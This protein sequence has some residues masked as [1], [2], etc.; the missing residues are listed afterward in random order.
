[1][2]ARLD[3][4]GDLCWPVSLI[5]S[6]QYVGHSDPCAVETKDKNDDSGEKRMRV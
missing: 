6:S 4:S 1:M 2:N 5:P 3:E